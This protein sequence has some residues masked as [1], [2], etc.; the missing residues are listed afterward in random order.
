[1]ITNSRL[2]LVQF[3]P[4]QAVL[5]G[6]PKRVVLLAALKCSST[7]GAKAAGV[8]LLPARMIALAPESIAVQRE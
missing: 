2:G 5:R 1:V 3:R 8:E 4:K 6:L 7:A